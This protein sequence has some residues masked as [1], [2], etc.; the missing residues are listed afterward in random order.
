MIVQSD[1]PDAENGLRKTSYVMA[2]KI[3]T[4]DKAALGHRIG[5]LDTTAMKMSH[6]ACGRC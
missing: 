6:S 1:E 3:L 5:V 2:D 4:V